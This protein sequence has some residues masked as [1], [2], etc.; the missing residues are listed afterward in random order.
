MRVKETP[1]PGVL[2][3]VP[4]RHGDPRGFFMETYHAERYARAGISAPFVQDNLSRSVRGTLRGLHFQQPH[5]QGKLVHVVVGAVFDVAVDVRLGSPTFGRWHGEELSAED[6]RQLYVPP[7]FAH[8]FYVLSEYALF[9]YKCTDVYVPEAERGVLWNDAEIGIRWPDEAPLLSARDRNAPR[10]RD[11]PVLP[12][13]APPG[14][15]PSS[16]TE[17]PR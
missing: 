10:L 1:L 2:L 7:G 11:A 3:I 8:G 13:Y 9:A 16:T 6:G 14:G 4:A 5:A 12:S 15:T 17:N